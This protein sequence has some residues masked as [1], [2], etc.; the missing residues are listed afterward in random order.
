MTTS[1]QEERKGLPARHRAIWTEAMVLAEAMP[2]TAKL[3]L[4]RCEAGRTYG[5]ERKAVEFLQKNGLVEKGAWWPS[6]LGRCVVEL[7]CR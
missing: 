3:A 2:V 5:K 6:Q 4:V 7:L 1:I